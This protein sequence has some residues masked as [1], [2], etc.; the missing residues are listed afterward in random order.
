MLARTRRSCLH[1]AGVLC[2]L[3]VSPRTVEHTTTTVRRIVSWAW[4]GA[5]ACASLPLTHHLMLRPCEQTM[6]IAR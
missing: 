5:H 3:A 6:K 4:H 1:L 2:T